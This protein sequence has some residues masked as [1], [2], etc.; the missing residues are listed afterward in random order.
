MVGD[1][2]RTGLSILLEPETYLKK[3]IYGSKWFDYLWGVDVLPCWGRLTTVPD[4]PISG[5]DTDM[6]QPGWVAWRGEAI[7]AGAYVEL[8]SALAKCSR[9]TNI[10]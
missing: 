3:L 7:C 4:H 5:C 1:Q 10:A 8:K 2:L 9:S 6:I